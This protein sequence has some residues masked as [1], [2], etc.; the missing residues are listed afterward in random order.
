M[1]PPV[2]APLGKTSSSA[3]AFAKSLLLA[4]GKDIFRSSAYKKKRGDLKHE[5]KSFMNKIKSKGPK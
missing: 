4:T 1:H 5:K 3:C 2:D